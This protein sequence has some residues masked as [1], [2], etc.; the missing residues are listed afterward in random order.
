MYVLWGKLA[1]RIGNRPILLGVGSI[2][3]IAPL[4]W[5]ITG[6]NDFSLWI[7]LPFLHLLTGGTL[8]AIDLC[9]N[10]LQIGIAPLS[11][12]SKYFGLVAAIAGI[13]GALGTTAG[14][15]LAQFWQ[16][17]GLFGLFILSS[18]L[19]L[20]A[21]IPLFFVTETQKTAAAK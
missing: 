5:L 11:G 3:A 6:R 7:W 1:D 21:L 10:N 8:A 19:R 15:F 16:S 12:Q 4:L 17:G 18:I 14:G 13:G 9:S 2:V 20:G